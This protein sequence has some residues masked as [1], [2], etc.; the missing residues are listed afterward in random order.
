MNQNDLYA[1]IDGKRY[2]RG[3]DSPQVRD[4]HKTM[5]ENNGNYKSLNISS[6]SSI[7]DTLGYKKTPMYQKPEIQNNQW[8]YKNP[9]TSSYNT[10]QNSDFGM[11]DIARIQKG[12]GVNSSLSGQYGMRGAS[13]R[14][15]LK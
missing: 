7:E 14:Y 3:F 1:Y 2:R 15:Q 5:S 12:Y 9:V 4:F 11:D 10:G 13:P 6:S 8:F